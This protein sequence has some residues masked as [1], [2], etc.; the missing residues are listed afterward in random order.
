[1]LN[2]V[3]L[4][5]LTYWAAGPWVEP[6]LAGGVL[7]KF[8]P[9]QTELSQVNVAGIATEWG[10]FLA[11][12]LGVLAWLA[13]RYTTT[14]YELAILRDGDRV[15]VFAGIATRKRIAQTLIL[16]GALG[17]LAGAVQMMG[18]VY[19]YTPALSDNTGYFG[20][21]IAILA[22]GS[23]LG[24]IAIA[25]LF[26][27]VI[28]GSGVLSTLSVS[29]G[30]STLLFGVVL[31]FAAVGDSFARFR[32]VREPDLGD[33]RLGA[34]AGQIVDGDGASIESVTP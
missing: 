24:V 1:M 26:A 7:S 34:A 13:L 5:W 25:F 31:L 10:L 18:N 11:I 21:A 14:A 32:V 19:Q 12:G 29:S 27:G 23:E 6:Y 30:A 33:R 4:A 3:A 22:A 16:G 8:I 28:V 20:V 17:G 2:F 15:G 9:T